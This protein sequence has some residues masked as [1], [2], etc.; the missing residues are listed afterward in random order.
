M[1]LDNLKNDW[2]NIDNLST[3]SA[4]MDQDVHQIIKF[5]NQKNRIKS[6]IPEAIL[7]LLNGYIAIMLIIFNHQF[8]TQLHQ[9]L[10]GLN[11]LFLLAQSILIISTIRLFNKKLTV[12][13]TYL[14]TLTSLKKECKNLNQRY[15]GILGLY[16]LILPLSI[17]LLPKIY[18]ENL[19][20]Q[21]I[22]IAY[23]IGLVI[24]SFLSIKIYRY[25]KNLI[26]RNE[27]FWVGLG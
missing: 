17:L 16:V 15:Y 9:I 22:F 14:Q 26:L 3:N 19:S 6:F 7:L 24:L 4:L 5:R 1:N 20:L 8:D 11:L 2:K 25:Y 10:S 12:S 21:Q 13:A 18:S 27:R 23:S